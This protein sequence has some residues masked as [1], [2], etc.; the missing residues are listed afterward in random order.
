M[1][2][3]YEMDFVGWAT[4]NGNCEY[5]GKRKLKPKLFLLNNNFLSENI[6]K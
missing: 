3:K 2:Q 4:N 5:F 1:L 6:L